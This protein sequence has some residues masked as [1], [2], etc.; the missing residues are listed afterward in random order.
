[1][2]QGL[3]AACHKPAEGFR[4]GGRSQSRKNLSI[5]SRILPW[6]NPLPT[7][8]IVYKMSVSVKFRPQTA[9][10]AAR[11]YA[12]SFFRSCGARN[13][14]NRGNFTP[15]RIVFVLYLPADG[16]GRTFLSAFVLY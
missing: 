9:G 15:L 1:M 10:C 5:N 12:A 11:A 2:H 3:C 16:A 7:I 13:G 6:Q 8:H 4:F 14:I